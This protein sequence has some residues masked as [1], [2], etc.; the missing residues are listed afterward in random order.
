MKK[1]N[2]NYTFYKYGFYSRRHKFFYYLGGLSSNSHFVLFLMLPCTLITCCIADKLIGKYI[3]DFNIYILVPIICLATIF[4][5]DTA[6]L[7]SKDKGVYL[8]DDGTVL[9]KNRCI[10]NFQYHD[11]NL[12]HKFE[13]IDILSVAILNEKGFFGAGDNQMPIPKHE[14]YILLKVELKGTFAFILEDNEGF[15]NE[16]LKRNNKIK[17]FQYPAE[18]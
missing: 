9:I 12:N 15:V 6:F 17:T 16:L 2:K 10:Y 8:Y 1:K 11:I 18:N 7:F 5:L 4:I 13:V 3:N 14:E